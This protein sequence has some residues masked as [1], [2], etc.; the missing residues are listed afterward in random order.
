MA[1]RRTSERNS[2]VKERLLLLS[3]SENTILSFEY[4]LVHESRL[5]KEVSGSL[6][7][8][9]VELTYSNNSLASIS[10]LLITCKQLPAFRDLNL[11]PSCMIPT[12]EYQMTPEEASYVR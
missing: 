12:R 9:K 11:V 3:S 1:K 6:N 10:E 4:K 7:F 8:G 5:T 2:V